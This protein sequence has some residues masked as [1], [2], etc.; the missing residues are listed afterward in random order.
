VYGDQAKQAAAIGDHTIHLKSEYALS[1]VIRPISSFSS[2]FLT[3]LTIPDDGSVSRA[4]L[5]TLTV[6]SN[7]AALMIVAKPHHNGQPRG[8]MGD[9]IIRAWAKAA[10]ETNAFNKLKIFVLRNTLLSRADILT[11]LSHLPA[12][13]HCIFTIRSMP[14]QESIHHHIEGWTKLDL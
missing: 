7:L 4:N 9:G 10:D 11:G 14:S 2:Q 3:M 1:D 8:E 13:C 12:L 6:L 5:L